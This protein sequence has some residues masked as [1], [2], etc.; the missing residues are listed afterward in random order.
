MFL[1]KKLNYTGIAGL[2]INGWAPGLEYGD[3]AVERRIGKPAWLLIAV[4]MSALFAHAASAACP[5]RAQAIA[6]KW[7][8]AEPVRGLSA[9]LAMQEAVCIRDQLI[10]RLQPSLG[11]ITGYKAGLTSKAVQQR[12]GYDQPVRG[13]LLAGML[14][15]ETRYPVSAAFGARPVAEADLLVEIKDGSINEA[16]THLD[17]LQ[18]LASVIPFIELPDLMIAEGEPLTGPVITAINVGARQGI[19]GSRPIPVQTTRA[20]ADRLADMR[21]VVTGAGGKTLSE[22]PGTAILGHPL[23]AVL[24]LVADLR[25][26]DIRLKAGDVLSLGAFSP[27]LPV[28][29][30]TS[31]AV[32]YIGLPGDP[33]IA[34]R[35]R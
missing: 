1:C 35:F 12:F 20:F 33:E 9:D 19:Y 2:C 3:G 13:V 29:A 8:R 24:W 6:E 34:V 4:A 7:R 15:P 30:T 28:H 21:V 22:S 23:N 14:R 17:V 16:R 10:G 26:A 32:R 11:R 25:K 31:V 5:D 18:G 27:P